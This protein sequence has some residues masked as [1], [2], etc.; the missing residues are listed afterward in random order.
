M[1]RHD[2]VMRILRIPP[3]LRL[4][5]SY[6]VGKINDMMVAQVNQF[7]RC[8]SQT[9]RHLP[10]TDKMEEQGSKRFH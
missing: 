4:D 9:V 8:L 6:D 1:G 2:R 5:P 3:T 7:G 10:C